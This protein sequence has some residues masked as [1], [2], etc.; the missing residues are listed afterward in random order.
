MN[1][2][3][4]LPQYTSRTTFEPH[5]AAPRAV[6]LE[7]YRPAGAHISDQVHFQTIADA[8]RNAVVR[9]VHTYHPTW[10]RQ[11]TL[12]TV[13]GHIQAVFNY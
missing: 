5:G 6:S 13:R 2:D 7:I 4:T 10:S 1:L 8:L 11:F 9:A 3:L 12:H